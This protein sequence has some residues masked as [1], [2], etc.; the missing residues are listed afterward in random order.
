ME[1]KINL[2]RKHQ[3]TNNIVKKLN[4]E[5][6][7]HRETVHNFQEKLL[8]ELPQWLPSFTEDRRDHQREQKKKRKPLNPAN[9]NTE[10]AL[11]IGLNQ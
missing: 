9:Y 5:N 10:P 2:K 8:D 3:N 6:C 11:G 1:M 4:V 7:Q